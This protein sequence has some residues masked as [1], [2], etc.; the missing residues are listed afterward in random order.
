LILIAPI[1][2]H[3]VRGMRGARRIVEEEG[4]V[5]RDL[6]L[7]T[8]IGDRLVRDLVIQVTSI[9]GDMG[10][11]FDEIGKVLIGLRAEKAKEMFKAFA[12][13]PTVERAGIRRRMPALSTVG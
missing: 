9:G 12:G 5:G 4:L 7:T 6:L 11:V 1:L 13:R 10:I 2:I 3:L 8:D